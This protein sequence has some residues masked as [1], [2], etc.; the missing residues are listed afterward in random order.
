MVEINSVLHQMMGPSC[1][2]GDMQA[3]LEVPQICATVVCISTVICK[4]QG[5]SALCLLLQG[6]DPGHAEQLSLDDAC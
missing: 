5:S 3:Y 6:Q 1:T 4:A 2:S